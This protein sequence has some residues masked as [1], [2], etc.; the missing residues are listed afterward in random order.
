MLVAISHYLTVNRF[1]A[2]THSDKSGPTPRVRAGVN[3]NT[4]CVLSTYDKHGTPQRESLPSDANASATF[5]NS[6]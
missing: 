3:G 1:L 2:L 6:T 4:Q 5:T